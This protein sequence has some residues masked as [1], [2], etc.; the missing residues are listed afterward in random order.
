M[1]APLAR[2]AMPASGEDLYISNMR[3]PAIRSW[4]FG[5]SA[6]PPGSAARRDHRGALG[7]ARLGARPAPATPGSTSCSCS[8][9]AADADLEGRAVALRPTALVN[10]LAGE[11][12]AFTF[13]RGTQ[14]FVA[15]LADDLIDHLLGPGGDERQ[16]LARGGV[17]EADEALAGTMAHLADEFGAGRSP[18]RALLFAWAG[19]R[20]ARAGR[21]HRCACRGAVAR[22]AGLGSCCAASSARSSSGWPTH[23][24][25]PSTRGRSPS[26]RPT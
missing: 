14:G 10:V 6:N 21:A 19:G 12:H 26:R 22:D 4:L 17:F 25:S 15:T 2:L 5:E 24:R 13:A 11:V 18:A 8:A 20:A 23:G 7:A 9:P 1:V 16:L 3:A